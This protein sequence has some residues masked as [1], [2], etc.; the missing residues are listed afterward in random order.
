MLDNESDL[1]C[2]TV[3]EGCRHSLMARK[4][5]KWRLQHLRTFL[6][7]MV[8]HLYKIC[9]DEYRQYAQRPDK[10]HFLQVLYDDYAYTL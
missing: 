8:E 7:D 2:I 5:N 10:R 9:L 3:M 6:Q 1:D 4:Y